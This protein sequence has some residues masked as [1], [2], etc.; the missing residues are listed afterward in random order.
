MRQLSPPIDFDAGA[1]AIWKAAQ[2]QMRQQGT[3]RRTDGPLL[4]MYVRNVRVAQRAREQAEEKPFHSDG[5]V[6]IPHVEL[7]VADKA[8]ER[9]LKLAASLVLTPEARRRHGIT[10]PSGATG[11]LE[12]LVG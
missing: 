1:R 3:W 8:E 6:M 12:K 4:A 9:A 10:I 2:S 7:A 11:E 5:S